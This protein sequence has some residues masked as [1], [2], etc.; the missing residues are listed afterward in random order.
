MKTFQS[1]HQESVE[2]VKSFIVDNDNSFIH[3]YFENIN[4]KYLYP[5]EFLKETF[6]KFNKNKLL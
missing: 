5:E 4:I 1:K 6:I 3:S 2:R